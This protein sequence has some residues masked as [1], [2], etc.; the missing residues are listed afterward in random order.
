MHEGKALDDALVARI[1]DA[2]VL[3]GFFF[4]VLGIPD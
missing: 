2:C 4:L 3:L 1:K